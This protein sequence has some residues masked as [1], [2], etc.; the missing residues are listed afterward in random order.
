MSWRENISKA[1]IVYVSAIPETAGD[2]ARDELGEVFRGAHAEH[3]NEVPLA[4]HGIDLGHSLD[5][6]QLA[7]ERR[8]R[9]ALRL[10]QHHGI[11]HGADPI[12]CRP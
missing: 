1:T 12:A 3:R 5:V 9:G 8:H 2:P 4:R 7:P 6:G 11:R 10:D